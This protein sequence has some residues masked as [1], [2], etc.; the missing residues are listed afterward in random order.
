MIKFRLPFI[1]NVLT[2]GN[3]N[4]LKANCTWKCKGP[5][6]TKAIVRKEKKRV[7]IFLLL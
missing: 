1:L 5:G 4:V 7:C 6:I 3:L 2:L